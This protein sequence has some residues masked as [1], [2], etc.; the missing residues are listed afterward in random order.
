MR[1]IDF[2][3]M[4]KVTGGLQQTPGVFETIGRWADSP[5]TTVGRAL[6]AAIDYVGSGAEGPINWGNP[7]NYAN[8]VGA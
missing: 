4:Q 1:V 8:T 7:A 2:C 5:F 6:D 3:E